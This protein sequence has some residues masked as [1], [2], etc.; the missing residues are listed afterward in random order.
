[1]VYRLKFYDRYYMDYRIAYESSL[2]E[3]LMNWGFW[4]DTTDEWCIHRMP[5]ID[6]YEMTLIGRSANFQ[7]DGTTL[8]R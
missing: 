4:M 7:I 6:A 3:L 5:H 1:M 2:Y 8:R